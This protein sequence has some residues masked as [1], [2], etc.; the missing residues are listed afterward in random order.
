M[1]KIR[2]FWKDMTRYLTE[3]WI[4]VR[5][6]KGRVAWPSFDTVKLSTKVVI[7][8]SVGLGMFIGGLDIFFGWLL[9]MIVGGK[10]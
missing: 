6:Q 10:V 7:I 1:E 4:E 2:T 3:V 9:K 8:S 5:P